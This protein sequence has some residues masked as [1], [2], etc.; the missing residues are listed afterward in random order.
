MRLKLEHVDDDGTATLGRMYIDGVWQCW[1]LEDTKREEKIAGKTRIPNGV[2]DIKLRPAGSWHER[3]KDLGFSLGVLHLQDVHGFTYILIHWGNYHQN[4]DGCILVGKG[5]GSDGDGV[6]AV[7]SSKTAYK[8][9]YEKV[10]AELLCGNEV[11]IE[12][13]G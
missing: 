7:W 5:K 8:E 4:T 6:H 13:T 10:S 11:T 2:Y 9:L 12:I 1:T 3:N